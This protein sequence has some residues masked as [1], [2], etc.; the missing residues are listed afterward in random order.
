MKKVWLITGCSSGFGKIL[1]RK[2]LEAKESVVVT[3]RNLS[4]LEGLKEKAHASS[5]FLPLDVTDES[6]RN[7]VIEKTVETFG[8]LDVLVNNAGY[9]LMGAVEE[10]SSASIKRQFDTNFF[11]LVSLTQ[12]ALPFMR[13]QNSGHIINISSIAGLAATPG[14]AFYNASKFAVEGFS[15]ALQLEVKHLGIH[16]SL[17]EPGPFR[18]DFA[19]RSLDISP[20]IKDYEAS[21]GLMRSYLKTA[22]GKQEGDP[23]KGAEAILE[24]AKKEN[25]PLRLLI[26]SAAIKR[27]DQKIESLKNSRESSSEIAQSCDYST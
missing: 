8:R 20:E 1:A 3:A 15:E 5:L 7:S 17:I 25:P 18:T 4:S 6:Q 19:G 12:K 10:C 9:G 22:N 2:L 13:K 16:V 27:L 26:G 24:L 23:E 11:G 14:A 21:A